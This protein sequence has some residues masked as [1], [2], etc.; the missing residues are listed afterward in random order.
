MTITNFLEQV[1]VLVDDIADVILSYNRIRVYRSVSG[2]AGN[3]EEI[4]A[5]TAAA[6]TF[7][8]ARLEPYVL[9]GKDFVIDIDGTEESFTFGAV[10]TAAAAAAEITSNTTATATDSG[11]Y[12]QVT[13]GT[14]GTAS[15]LEINTAS[16]GAVALGMY[17][18][19]NDHGEE[20]WVTLSGATKLYYVNDYQGSTD[21]WYKYRF[22]NTTNQAISDWS[23]AYQG[24]E[25]GALDPQ[26]IIYG[27]GYLVDTEGK[28]M[29]NVRIT[30][31]NK[32]LPKLVDD[33]IIAGTQ[34]TYYTEDDGFVS[35]PLIKGATV[36][37]SIENTSLV[38]DIDVPDTGDTFDLM[39]TDMQDAIGIVS[40]DLTDATR[41]TI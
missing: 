9:D 36:T 1:P 38:R 30:I 31:M 21:Y 37:L 35:I 13:S 15:T 26:Y 24:R 14:T 11:G 29:P 41:T 2:V 17:V 28:P 32:Y 16:E 40:Y 19:D 25:E 33:K 5:T 8:G 39:T 27:T 6:A 18:G 12:V 3:F 22:Y 10:T 4:T 7:T 34:Y 20:S 23:S